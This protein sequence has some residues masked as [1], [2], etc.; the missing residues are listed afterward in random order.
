MRSTLDD[1]IGPAP[2]DLARTAREALAIVVYATAWWLGYHVSTDYWFLPA[3]LRFVSLLATPRRLWAWLALS[4]FVAIV[5]IVLQGAGYRTWLGFVLGVFGPWLIHA[6]V[7]AVADRSGLL[8][9]PDTPRRMGRLLLAM[10]V[11]A[12]VTAALL[13]AMRFIEDPGT[14]SDPLLYLLRFSIGDY[15]AMLIVTPLWLH[16]ST[17]RLAGTRA[18]LFD[19]AV[20]YLPLL[21]LV[22]LVPALRSHAITYI[23]LLAL[24]PMVFMVFRHGWEGAGWSLACT[25]VALY[26]IGEA[27]DMR[28]TQDV[29]QVF[30]ALVGSISLMLGAAIVA[31]RNARDELARRNDAL[32]AQADELRALS[33]RLVR[34]QEDE[35]RRIARELQ[36]E[37]EQGMTALGTRLGMLARTPLEPAQIA[38]VDSLRS[39]AQDIHASVR[40]VLHHV[41][42]VAL[43]RHGLEHALRAGPIRDLLADAEVQFDLRV[44]GSLAV[45]D[46]DVQGA[47]YRICQEAAVD[48]VRQRRGRRF[49]IDLRTSGLKPGQHAVEL[50]VGYGPLP[51]PWAEDDAAA[52]PELLPGTR[53]RVF[54]L[55]GR[56]RC[57]VED[58]AIRHRVEF[59]TAA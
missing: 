55:G 13:T 1:G 14:F 54:A 7:V 47:L 48:C 44:R 5:T 9:E 31:L 40:E 29:M 50:E 32:A 46:A 12:L 38:A 41:R 19:L 16:A 35:Q 15:I 25:S 37:L 23:G 33:E 18:I 21:A 10:L 8:R 17:R 52:V 36:G 59:V 2:G 34:A 27:L 3:G 49:S 30:L 26:A 6:S 39:L 20:L 45:L 24:V 42:P 11:A 51:E 43:D 57:F 53:D 58:D 4:E 28:V 56:Y 22:L